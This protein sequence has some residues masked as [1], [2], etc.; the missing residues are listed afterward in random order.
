MR[1]VSHPP[2]PPTVV[3]PGRRTDHAQ[4]LALLQ[5]HPIPSHRPSRLGQRARLGLG[6]AYWGD[7]PCKVASGLLRRR[8]VGQAGSAPE[9]RWTSARERTFLL[10]LSFSAVHPRGVRVHVNLLAT[11]SRLLGVLSRDD[12][13]NPAKYIDGRDYKESTPPSLFLCP[14]ISGITDAIASGNHL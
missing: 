14:V 13:A 1:S 11:L 4:V 8:Q 2:S 3:I 7:G 10:F 6:C 5:W 12:A 9:K